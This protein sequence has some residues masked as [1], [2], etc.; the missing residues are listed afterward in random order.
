MKQISLLLLLFAWLLPAAAAIE[1]YQFKDAETEALYK[2]LIAELRC[3]VCQNQNLADSDADLAKDL[4]QQT[5]EMLQQ[6]KGRA[7]IVEY[8]VNRYGDFVLYRPPIKS[9]TYLLWLGPFALLL[10]VLVAVF[11]RFRK[12]E[13]LAPPEPEAVKRA[14]SLLDDDAAKGDKQ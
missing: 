12:P 5:Y 11:I 2:E 8:M 7:E 6:G 14:R 9:S 10:I 13:T 4:R 1:A 3:L